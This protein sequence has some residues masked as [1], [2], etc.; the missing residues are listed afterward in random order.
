[1]KL[2][3]KTFDRSS[4][5]LNLVKNSIV[6]LVFTKKRIENVRMSDDSRDK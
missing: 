6:R 2:M 5:K 1:M 4:Y 3:T